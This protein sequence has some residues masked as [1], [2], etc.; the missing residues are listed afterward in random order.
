MG[1]IGVMELYPIVAFLIS[2]LDLEPLCQ[3]QW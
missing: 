3:F 2:T 1:D